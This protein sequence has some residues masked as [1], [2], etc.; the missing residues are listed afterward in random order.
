MTGDSRTSAQNVGLLGDIGDIS[1]EDAGGVEG[2]AP[3]LA[4]RQGVK[5]A[6]LRVAASP[7]PPALP[8]GWGSSQD[9]F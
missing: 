7:A 4:A 3:A 6:L 9:V 2:M 8:G 1:A 5:R